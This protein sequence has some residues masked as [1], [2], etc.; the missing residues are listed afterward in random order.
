VEVLPTVDDDRLPGDERGRGA[1]EVGD[2][3]DD[4]L[5]PLVA[6]DRAG[7][8]RDVAELLDHLGVLLDPVR[9]REAR[10]D[11]VDP[12]PVAAELLRERPGERDDR[13]L[14]RHVVEQERDAAKRRARRDVDDRAAAPLAHRRDGGAAG[15]EHRR[16]VDVH[17]LLPF[18]ERDLGERPHLERGVEA[19]VVDEHVEAATPRER[20]V[21]EPR[22]LRLVGD[23]GGEA[24]PVRVRRG[25]LLGAAQVGDDDPGA[26]GSEP[27]GDRPADP[28]RRSGDDGDLP[29]K[30]RH[31]PLF[32][33]IGENDVG[34]RMRF[35]CVWISGWILARNACQSLLACR[36][37]RR[38]S[39]SAKLV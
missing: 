39:R 15:Q 34:T 31:D 7:C 13:A 21:D 14:A 20:L 4:V 35:D 26:L 3:P 11:A 16:D 33:A 17:H 1:G 36:A 27:V 2:G 28:L 12:D 9:H 5:R 32:Y 8:D 10:G 29:L 19:R 6:L 25:R 18:P 22:D 37:A 24:H 38:S 23:V 30:L